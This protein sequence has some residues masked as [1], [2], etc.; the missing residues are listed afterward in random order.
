MFFETHDVFRSHDA[1]M[2]QIR[3]DMV[4]SRKVFWEKLAIP[5][6]FFRRPAWDKFAGAVDTYAADTL[7][8][9]GQ[10]NQIGSTHD[11]G[12]RFARAFDVTFLDDDGTE[13]YGWQTCW[14]PGVS[15]IL[16]AVIS[17]H[18]DDRGLRLPSILAPSQIVIIPIP[19]G[20]NSGQEEKI[21]SYS[22]EV[23]VACASDGWRC[24]RDSS[25]N[26]P[27]YKFNHWELMGVPLRI[28]VGLREA[29]RREVTIALRT[30]GQKIAA[31]IDALGQ[32]LPDLIRRSDRELAEDASLF[33]KSAT[34]DAGTMDELLAV[35]DR[36]RGFV[37]VPFC[38][39]TQ[40]GEACADILKR[41]A[42]GIIVC[43]VPL[44]DEGSQHQDGV[45]IVCGKPSRELV[46][47]ARSF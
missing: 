14:G 13:K 31:P 5:H 2:A 21:I 19:K 15:R 8:P 28:E 1:A 40:K 32:V 44:E 11:L 18:G 7:L 29:E 46:Y 42:H 36:H 4:M 20:K 34:A 47:T 26:S 9:D 43:G 27:G 38:S 41:E 39:I 24:S 12:Q 10:R 30:T 22:E 33:F 45:C 3:R 25:D 35:L 37:R 16:A 17:T 6:L 23:A